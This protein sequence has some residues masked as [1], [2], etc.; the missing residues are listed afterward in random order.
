MPEEPDLLLVQA[1][2]PTPDLEADR[3]YGE[4]R[5]SYENARLALQ[6]ELLEAKIDDLVQDRDQRKTY[7][8]RLFRLI[9]CWL[10]A[11]GL[12]VLLDGFSCIPFALSVPVLTTIIGS[13]TVAVLGL[14][15]IVVNYLFPKR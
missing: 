12:I 15:A 8:N 2:E 5:Q 7:S 9:V 3:L 11:I 14:F 4:E 1:A 6:N 10:M 13:T